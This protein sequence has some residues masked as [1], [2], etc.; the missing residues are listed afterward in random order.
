MSNIYNRIK[1]FLPN[2]LKH[3]IKRMLGLLPPSTVPPEMRKAYNR[4]SERS[5]PRKS[6]DSENRNKTTSEATISCLCRQDFFEHPMFGYWYDKL[7]NDWKQY[8]LE[9]TDFG[10]KEIPSDR[11]LYH[12]K[13]WEFIYIIQSLY[14]RNCLQP[15]TRGLGFAVGREP[16]PALLAAH[17]CQITATDLESNEAENLGWVAA[18]QFSDLGLEQLNRFQICPPEEFSKRVAY[19]SVDMNAIPSDL[20]DYD[21]CWSSCAFEHLGSI[22]KG[23]DFVVNAM[24]TLKPGGIAVHTTEFNLSSD[25]QTID[26]QFE[27]VLFRKKDIL[28]LSRRLTSLGHDVVPIDFSTGQGPVDSFIDLH[29]YFRKNMFLKFRVE[30]YVSTS[31]GLIIRK[32]E[33]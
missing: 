5:I 10:Q 22:E 18:G 31:I 23:L 15:G 1:R 19:R 2:S 21:F 29:P 14:E 13:L 3:Q 33:K 20:V 28:D 25:D 4:A 11:I 16:L 32:G 26:N 24:K 27:F 30:G 7:E 6:I 9:V 8:I 17:G 12:R